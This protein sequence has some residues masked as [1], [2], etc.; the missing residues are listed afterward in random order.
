M[1]FRQQFEDRLHFFVEECDSLQGFQLLVDTEDAFGGL[2]SCIVQELV[3]EYGQKGIF[4]ITPSPN[5]R[6]LDKVVH[7]MWVCSICTLYIRINA[8]Y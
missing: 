1:Q 3:E 8:G 4:S 6:P 7:V 2:G 5:T